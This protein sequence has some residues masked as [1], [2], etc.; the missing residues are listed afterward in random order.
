MYVHVGTMLRS[1]GSI[2]CLTSV[3]SWTAV[4]MFGV[5]FVYVV[6]CVTMLLLSL[7]GYRGPL[8]SMTLIVYF[9]FVVMT[10]MYG[11]ILNNTT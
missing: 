1:S 7:V 4:L 11:H 6:S 5:H 3:F 10:T 9:D 8:S 2:Y